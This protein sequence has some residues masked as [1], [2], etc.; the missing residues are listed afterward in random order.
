MKSLNTNTSAKPILP[1]VAQFSG[2]DRD[3]FLEQLKEDFSTFEWTTENGNTKTFKTSINHEVE[4]MIS[5]IELIKFFQKQ[6]PIAILTPIK[7]F[8]GKEQL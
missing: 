3:A 4:K 1:P 5:R 7:S 8:K 2:A 6:R